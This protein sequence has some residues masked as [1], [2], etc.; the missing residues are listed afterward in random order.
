M[1]GMQ[2]NFLPLINFC[3]FWQWKVDPVD[4]PKRRKSWIDLV[5]HRETQYSYKKVWCKSF[6][7]Q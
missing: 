1:L 7:V 4:N 5:N 2:I 3:K 6:D